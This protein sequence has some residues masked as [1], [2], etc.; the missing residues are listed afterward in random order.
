MS[1]TNYKCYDTQCQETARDN[2]AKRNLELHSAPQ[3]SRAL[4]GKLLFRVFDFAERRRSAQASVSRDVQ[5]PATKR[6][7]LFIIDPISLQAL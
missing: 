3:R 5:T 6:D 2:R 7:E 4:V 1:C